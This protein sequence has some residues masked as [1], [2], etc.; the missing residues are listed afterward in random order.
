MADGGNGDRGARVL[1]IAAC[2]DGVFLVADGKGVILFDHVDVD[3]PSDW[4]G[5]DRVV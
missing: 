3:D 5:A 2:L 1:L 4:E